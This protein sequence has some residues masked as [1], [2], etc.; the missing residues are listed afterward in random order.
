MR[1][2]EDKIAQLLQED[3][4]KPLSPQTLTDYP[5]GNNSRSVVQLKGT[6]R[7]YVSNILR[8]SDVAKA[9]RSKIASTASTI[10]T[11][12]KIELDQLVDLN[13]Q[14]EQKLLR[15]LQRNNGLEREVNKLR[16]ELILKQEQR[17]NLIGR[18]TLSRTIQADQKDLA[19]SSDN[20]FSKAYTL[21]LNQCIGNVNEL[22]SERELLEFELCSMR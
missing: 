21:A 11:S 17:K 4:T 13:S 22:N 2:K 16:N 1:W 20:T 14:S 18:S 3:W 8:N 9:L 5:C 7:E 12:P 15:T 19:V 6:F 10:E